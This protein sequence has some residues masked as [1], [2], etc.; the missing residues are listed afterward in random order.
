LRY[1]LGVS[2]SETDLPKPS[3]PDPLQVLTATPSP[4]PDVKPPP[5]L[6]P[7]VQTKSVVEAQ[8]SPEIPAKIE[9][10]AEAT[11]E[12]PTKIEPAAEAAPEIPAKIEPETRAA[13]AQAPPMKKRVM[14]RDQLYRQN[15]DWSLNAD[16][17]LT[18]L[19]F[20][21]VD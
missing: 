8:A 16:S 1:P 14:N 3:R 4:T 21:R 20:G 17:F 10:T 2:T 6:A 5:V 15:H 9:P 7:A 18:Y 13:R 12:I 19:F 11:P